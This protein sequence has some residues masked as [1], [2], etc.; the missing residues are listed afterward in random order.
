MT[1]AKPYA[2][3]PWTDAE[4]D[5]LCDHIADGGGF[6]TAGKM[7]GRTK[8]SCVSRFHKIARSLGSQAA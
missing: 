6:G 3:R 8:N 2:T 5:I 7:L 1:N 4:S